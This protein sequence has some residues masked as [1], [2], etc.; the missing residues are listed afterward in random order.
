MRTRRPVVLLLSVLVALLAASAAK[1]DGE[2]GVVIQD[3][4]SVRTF[5]VAFKG[6]SIRGDQL[7]TSAG[8]T[9]GQ[10]GGSARTVCSISGT[11]CADASSF[12]SCFCKCQSGGG[13][14]TYWAFFTQRYGNPWTYSTIGFNL[15][16][17]RDGDLHGWRWGKG[18]L[19]SAPPPSSVSFEQIC[20]HAP[21]GGLQATATPPAPTAVIT[22]ALSPTAG[23]ALTATSTSNPATAAPPP[24]STSA[25]AT[26]SSTSVPSPT[27]LITIGSP[28]T[29]EAGNADE[30]RAESDGGGAPTGLIAFAGVAAVLGLGIAFAVVR[31]RSHG[32]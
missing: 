8:L 20:G 9:F 13:D 23:S 28:V 11:G 5:C 31:R 12:D 7:L 17:A 29:R 18:S 6:D 25:S 21:R 3:G 10:F 24:P 2:A 19:Q 15:A 26:I 14:C 1:A 4:D 27:A 30:T 16:S 32:A 22:T